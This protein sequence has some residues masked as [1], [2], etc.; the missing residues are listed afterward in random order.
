MATGAELLQLSPVGGAQDV[1]P[2]DVALEVLGV[3][4]DTAP[5]GPGFGDGFS[6]AQG[7]QLVDAEPRF[8]GDGDEGVVACVVLRVGD[9]EDGLDL[10]AGRGLRRRGEEAGHAPSTR[11]LP[12][13][14]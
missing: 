1:L 8:G 14:K 2:A 6:S 4:H 3:E 10:L 7:H 12:A 11:R 9:D 13:V 5:G